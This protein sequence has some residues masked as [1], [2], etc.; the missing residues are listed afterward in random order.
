V[1]SLGAK[2]PSLHSILLPSKVRKMGDFMLGI[3][4]NRN[5][6]GKETQIKA[7]MS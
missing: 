3:Q 5:L 4:V 7:I 6:I 2:D 1:I